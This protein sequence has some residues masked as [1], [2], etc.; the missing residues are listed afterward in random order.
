MHCSTLCPGHVRRF[1]R[2][3]ILGCNLLSGVLSAPRLAGKPFGLKT[4]IQGFLPEA[5]EETKTSSVFLPAWTRRKQMHSLTCCVLAWNQTLCQYSAMTAMVLKITSE[6]RHPVTYKL[7]NLLHQKANV[8]PDFLEG[9][10]V[11]T[12]MR[13]CNGNF[14]P[15]GWVRVLQSLGAQTA[16]QQQMLSA[17]TNMVPQLSSGGKRTAGFSE[18]GACF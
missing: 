6:Q 5:S 1:Q 10:W 7:N 11:G 8:F 3:A 16:L 15:V 13:K 14:Q 12:K 2:S 9:W 4:P 17:T 18:D